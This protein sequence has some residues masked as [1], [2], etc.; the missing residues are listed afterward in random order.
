MVT[1]SFLKEFSPKI[2]TCSQKKIG[3]FLQVAN[4]A[5]YR[6]RKSKTAHTSMVDPRQTILFKLVKILKLPGVRN[7]EE[8]NRRLRL[9]MK[10][11]GVKK[12]GSLFFMVWWN[13]P[14]HNWVGISTPPD[15]KSP[16]NQ[17]G[18]PWFVSGSSGGSKK[19]LEQVPGSVRDGYFTHFLWTFFMV[20]V[21]DILYLIYIYICI[22]IH[23]FLGSTHGFFKKN[24][25]RCLWLQQ[26]KG[27]SPPPFPTFQPPP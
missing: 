14:P 11:W 25:H 24:T 4:L 6:I 5:S 17:T 15:H 26:K 16:G 21:H 18:R 8:K 12:T 7:G 22:P 13:N 19:W 2:G 20:V 1:S 27:Q 10:Y 3:T 23:P 9:S